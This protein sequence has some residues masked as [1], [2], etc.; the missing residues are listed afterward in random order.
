MHL[1][2]M[3]THEALPTSPATAPADAFGLEPLL[4]VTEVAAY[5]GV[6]VSTLYDRRTRGKG[7]AAY[8]FG[9]HLKF[10]VSDVRSWL[11]EQRQSGSPRIDAPRAGDLTGPATLTIGSFGEIITRILPSGRLEARTRHRDWD[12]RS[13]IVQATADTAKA[14]ERALKTSGG[15]SES[16]TPHPAP[17][18]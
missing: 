6:P 17:A 13:R 1:T 16:S 7:P 4:D 14:A 2:G 11:A 5:L 8:R 15:R 3:N 18:T 9:K 10:A 12:G